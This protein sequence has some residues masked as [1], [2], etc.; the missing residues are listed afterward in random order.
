MVGEPFELERRQRAPDARLDLDR[1]NAQDRE[2]ETRA[3]IAGELERRDERLPLVASRRRRDERPVAERVLERRPA[4]L[5]EPR[6]G[7]RALRPRLERPGP[8]GEAGRREL[9]LL[10]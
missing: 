10:P 6:R 7:K 2:V 1:R 8:V 9:A 4:E 3:A 5:G